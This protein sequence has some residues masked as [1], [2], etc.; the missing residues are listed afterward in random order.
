MRDARDVAAIRALER[1]VDE[2][3]RA[4]AALAKRLAELERKREAPP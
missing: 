3:E 1:R 4:L 2:L